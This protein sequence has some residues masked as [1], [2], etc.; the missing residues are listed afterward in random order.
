VQAKK[1]LQVGSGLDW[2]WIRFGEQKH[3]SL[4]LL[5]SSIVLSRVLL[6]LNC[7]YTD[8]QTNPLLPTPRGTPEFTP[9]VLR[10]ETVP[11][12][13]PFPRQRIFLK[14]CRPSPEP[15]FLAESPVRGKL[16]HDPSLLGHS[17]IPKRSILALVRG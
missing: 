4:R 6:R 3:I 10:R 13:L 8:L 2:S 11:G 16:R 17:N 7:A 5:Q 15:E 1:A 9:V 12:R 14:V